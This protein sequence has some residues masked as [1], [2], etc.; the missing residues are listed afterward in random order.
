MNC[1]HCG[2]ML[3]EGSATCTVC[4]TPV[5]AASGSGAVQ[6]VTERVG[7]GILG[8]LIGALIG[9]ASIIL[10]SRL[11]YVAA[12]SG[13]LIAF[14]TLKGYEL[15]GKRLSK[16]GVIISIVLMVLTPFLAHGI[17]LIVQLHAEL[18][19]YGL[20]LSDTLTFLVELLQ[21]DAELLQTYLSELGMVYLFVAL[22][23]FSII[24]N[25]LR[26]I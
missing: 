1:E 24:R 7:L 2:A 13:V 8:A 25:A 18:Q 3:T 21:T 11:G 4:G 15:L 9:G 23:A 14:G 19:G 17:D 5:K 16:T 26:N 22:G 6:P 20:T 12:L 10:L